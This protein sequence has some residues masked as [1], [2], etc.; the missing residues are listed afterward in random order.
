MTPPNWL[1][2]NGGIGSVG[3]SKKFF[4]SKAELRRN[5]KTSP[6]I[7]FVPVLL[8]ALIMPPIDRPYSAGALWV[9]T[10]N[11][12]IDSTP[13][14]CPPAPPGVKFWESFM[15]VPSSMNRLEVRRAPPTEN[16]VPRPWFGLAPAEVATVTP[17]WRYI[18]WSKL[19]PFRG[20][21]RIFF[22][23]T[24]PPIVAV[25]VSTS[26]PVL[27][28]MTCSLR[29]PTSILKFVTASSATVS[30]KELSVTLKPC[31]SART[32]YR[33]TGKASTR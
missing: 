15:S 14:I 29:D 12:L 32:S 19:R 17:G 1:R 23:S 11:S 20:K 24:N 28:T 22:S 7:L 33:P 3:L 21:S 10:L 6:W 26:V 5:S 31:R 30:V 16:L 13:N 25:V 18:N 8:T 2:L 4:A 9:I 27:V